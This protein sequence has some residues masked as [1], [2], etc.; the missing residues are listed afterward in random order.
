MDLKKSTHHQEEY[1]L[2]IVT[3]KGYLRTL[4]A[5]FQVKCIKDLFN[6]KNGSYVYVDA[7]AG[8]H[9]CILIY[10]V[11]GNWHPYDLFQIKIKF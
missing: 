5:P 8:H 1:S 6:C 10:R 4:Q 7:V 2:T 11:L 9:H 3:G